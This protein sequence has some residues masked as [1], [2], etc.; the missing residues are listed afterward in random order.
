MRS[1]W[2]LGREMV[3]L[4]NKRFTWPDEFGES[5]YRLVMRKYKVSRLPRQQ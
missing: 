4:I 1:A 3:Q 5:L 2:E